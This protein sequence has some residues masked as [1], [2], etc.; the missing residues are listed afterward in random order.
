MPHRETAG[1]SSASAGI[2]SVV[3][4]GSTL[5]K[6]LIWRENAGLRAARIRQSVGLQST[7]GR[8]KCCIHDRV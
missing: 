5:A 6:P 2:N 4:I 1:P 7:A 3:S 8:L